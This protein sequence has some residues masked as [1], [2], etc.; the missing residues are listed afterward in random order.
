[1][2][3]YHISGWHNI[4]ANSSLHVDGVTAEDI[5]SIL[6][7]LN[8]HKLVQ[9]WNTYVDNLFQHVVN[10]DN[11]HHLTID[12]LKTTVIQILY[13]RWRSVGYEGNIDEFITI[14]FN[15]LEFATWEEILEGTSETKIMSVYDLA[16][17]ITRH[18]ESLDSHSA[19]LQ[20]FFT[21]GAEY[22]P[23]PVLVLTGLSSNE[24]RHPTSTDPVSGTKTIKLN[25]GM[26]NRFGIVLSHDI[27]KSFYYRIEDQFN[28]GWS[29]SFD[30]STGIFNVRYSHA[31][32]IL[33][34]LPLPVSQLTER[35][36]FIL[37]FDKTEVSIYLENHEKRVINI[38]QLYQL[39][40]DIS[41][42]KVQIADPYPREGYLK[43]TPVTGSNQFILY[44]ACVPEEGMLHL[45]SLLEEY[46]HG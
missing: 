16:N 31:D 37:N 32:E 11:P 2:K 45:I 18:D 33:T 43:F 20:Q 15:Y 9:L 30:Q 34:T 10:F 19:Q 21:S 13:S 36:K 6:H 4:S 42:I 27:S 40:G 7:N 35:V 17:L 46:A 39:V 14:L 41:P 23:T 29:I 25:T 8:S 26:P 28:L 3:K 24:I 44:N 12:Q 38:I 5:K 1:M 22:I